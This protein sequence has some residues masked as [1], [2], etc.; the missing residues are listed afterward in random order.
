MYVCDSIWLHAFVSVFRDKHLEINYWNAS[1]CCQNFFALVVDF[2]P[3]VF[4][5]SPE[6]FSPGL[7]T[8]Q[9]LQCWFV[10]FL[11]CLSV[12]MVGIVLFR[13]VRNNFNLHLI[14]MYFR[15]LISLQNPYIHAYIPTLT[16]ITNTYICICICEY[17]FSYM[18]NVKLY[19]PQATCIWINLPIYTTYIHMKN[20][21]YV[22]LLML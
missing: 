21:V 18:G 16:F 2:S 14:L 6:F 17:I 4:C 5:Q 3:T 11:C 9:Q 13:F 19:I 22:Y 15:L 10:S 1:K 8:F 12:L 7:P 20:F